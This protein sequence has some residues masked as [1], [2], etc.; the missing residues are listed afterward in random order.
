MHDKGYVNDLFKE[1]MLDNLDSILEEIDILHIS[2]N[3]E[4]NR[5]I[6]DKILPVVKKEEESLF[7]ALFAV[8]TSQSS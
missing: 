3:L 7:V 1:Q 8:I 4:E 6:L 5:G 2:A